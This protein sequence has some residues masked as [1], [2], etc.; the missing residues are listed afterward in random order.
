[1]TSAQELESVVREVFAQKGVDLPFVER[2]PGHASQKVHNPHKKTG[3]GGGEKE[4][5]RIAR[6]KEGLK[7]V[8]MKPAGAI[9]KWNPKTKAGSRERLNEITASQLTLELQD[10]FV[11]P[12]QKD[13]QSKWEAANKRG[14]SRGKKLYSKPLGKA[15]RD[16]F[17]RALHMEKD[18]P[19][20]SKSKQGA[21]TEN[22][23]DQNVFGAT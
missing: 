11:S 17:N 6:N 22:I 1:M 9:G 18:I 8:E 13:L 12:K 5:D 2:H 19:V 15:K 10:R 23:R 20:F 16:D 7:G 3:G 4:S 14:D 21:R